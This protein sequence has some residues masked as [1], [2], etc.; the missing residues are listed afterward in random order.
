MLA[1][2]CTSYRIAKI[3]GSGIQTTAKANEL[4]TVMT[5]CIYAYCKLVKVPSTGLLWSG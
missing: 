5:V 1:A 3:Y 2:L 4:S